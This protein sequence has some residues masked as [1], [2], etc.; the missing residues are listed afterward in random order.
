ML[1]LFALLDIFS[2]VTGVLEK[3]IDMPLGGAICKRAK[4]VVW[5][6]YLQVF[7]LQGIIMW[8]V[9]NPAYAVFANL[10]SEF[11]LPQYISITL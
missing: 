6:A 11:G 4:N 2:S 10:V 5:R 9:L 8:V 3:I 1:G 7:M